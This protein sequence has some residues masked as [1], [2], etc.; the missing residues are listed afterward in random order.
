MNQMRSN[1]IISLLLESFIKVQH[2]LFHDRAFVLC[3]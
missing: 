2:I 1:K 3:F